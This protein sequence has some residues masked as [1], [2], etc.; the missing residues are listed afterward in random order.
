QNDQSDL[1]VSSWEKHHSIM[2]TSYQP[3]ALWPIFCRIPD[4][5]SRPHPASAGAADCEPP[6]N[7]LKMGWHRA[8]SSAQRLSADPPL[9][10]H[11]RGMAESIGVHPADNPYCERKAHS[12]TPDR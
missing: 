12:N 1:H 11:R 3:S 5:L 9:L 4:T 7:R 8:T 6:Q 2:A 10:P